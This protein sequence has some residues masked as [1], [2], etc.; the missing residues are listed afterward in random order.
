MAVNPEFRMKSFRGHFIDNPGFKKVKKA[1]DVNVMLSEKVEFS[2]VD[3]RAWSLNMASVS[4][5][6]AYIKYI[7]L[8]VCIYVCK[9][10][11]IH[12]YIV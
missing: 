3:K 7:Y 6:I 11:Y 8:Y 1:H 9:N 10:I 2:V 5:L 12:T 4:A